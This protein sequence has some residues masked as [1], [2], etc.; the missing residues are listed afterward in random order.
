MDTLIVRKADGS[1]KLLIYRKATHTDQYLNFGSHHPIHHKLGVVRTLM[2]RMNTI[3]SEDSDRELEEAKIKKA[4]ALC[5]YPDWSFTKVKR[6]IENKKTKKPAKKS[7]LTDKSKGLV[8]I[9]YVNGLSE[10]ANRIFRRHGIA[11]AMRPHSSLRKMLVH[12][13]DKRDPD[14]TT[15]VVYEIP[16]SNCKHTYVGETGRLLGTRV[17]EH[18]DESNK[19]AVERK[20]YTRQNKKLS[21]SEYSKSGI[22]D[23]ALQKNHVINWDGA[24]V[25]AKEDH[26]LTRKIREAIWIRKKSPLVMNRDEGAHYIS[27][28]YDPLLSSRTAPSG[29]SKDQKSTL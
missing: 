19:I 14:A 7:D 20:N 10:K 22:A 8:V 12:P 3:V 18:K 16:C 11:T 4:L 2:D 27:H 29:G 1:V 13:K 26:Q 6:Q 24:S 5:G 21:E 25:L 17:E 23:H 15:D 9:P 28:V